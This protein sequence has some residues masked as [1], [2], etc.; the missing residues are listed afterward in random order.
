M[1]LPTVH[2]DMT[3]SMCLVLCISNKVKRKL[4]GRVQ[5]LPHQLNK[6]FIHVTYHPLTDVQAISHHLRDKR[7]L[8]LK[9]LTPK[10]LSFLALAFANAGV[11]DEQLFHSISQVRW[12]FLTF[13]RCHFLI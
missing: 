3:L 2:S 10:E 12:Y 4:Q 9:L 5:E 13:D 11:K 7:N 8:W 6:A 1:S